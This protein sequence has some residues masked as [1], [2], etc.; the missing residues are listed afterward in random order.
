MAMMFA[1]LQLYPPEASGDDDPYPLDI[2]ALDAS[3]ARLERFLLD[4]RERYRD[5]CAAWER[6]DWSDEYEDEQAYMGITKAYGVCGN[7]ITGTTFQIVKCLEARA[8]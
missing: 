1:L 4:Y 3:K 7:L 2:I 6:E 8:L 5:A